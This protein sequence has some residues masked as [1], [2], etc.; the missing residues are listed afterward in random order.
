MPKFQKDKTPRSKIKSVLRRAWLE[1]RERAA[2]LKRDKYTCQKCGVKQSRAKGKEIKV[3]VHHKLQID[4][5]DV[6]DYIY[7]EVLRTPEAHQTLCPSCHE[8]IHE[9][10]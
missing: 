6:I 2:A 1:S 5:E 9:K 8:N 10:K 4:W 3:E 7:A